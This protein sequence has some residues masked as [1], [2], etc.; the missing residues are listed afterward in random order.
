MKMEAA[1]KARTRHWRTRDGRSILIEDMDDEHLANTEAYLMRQLGPALMLYEMGKILV[2]DPY[3][4][5]Y[6]GDWA[7][8]VYLLRMREERK[9]RDTLGIKIPR[10]ENQ[11]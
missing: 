4:L 10:T 5:R 9:R 2:A 7:L 1:L 11:V 3:E 8:W 6:D